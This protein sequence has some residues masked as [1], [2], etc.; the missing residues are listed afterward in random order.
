MKLT[1]KQQKF[2]EEYLI[3]LNA[4]QAAIRAGYS[5]ETYGSIGHENL[6]KPEIQE[7]IT[8]LQQEL[9]TKTGITKERV[10]AEFAKIAFFDLRDAYTGDGSL[11][12]P[13]ELSDEAAG[14]ISGIDV[15]EERVSD[16]DSEE[17]IV[18]G[19]TKKIKLHDKI[20]ALDSLSKHLGLYEKDNRQKEIPVTFNYN[21]LSDQALREIAALR[22]TE[23]ESDAG[24]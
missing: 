23:G 19:T 2:C 11:K 21:G 16:E 14:A 10:L 7:Y 4:S 6:Q 15:Y 9:Q 22:P 20:R 12:A 3:D 1:P 13:N 18:V 24:K 17:K 8:I 5:K